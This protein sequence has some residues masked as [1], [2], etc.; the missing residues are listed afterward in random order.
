MNSEQSTAIDSD[1]GLQTKSAASSPRVSNDLLTTGTSDTAKNAA[2][3][4]VA[5]RFAVAIT[6]AM[7]DLI[8]PHD[9]A[10]PIARQFMPDAQELTDS[11]LDQADPIGDETHS[12][13]PGIVH[14]YPDRLLLTP[15]RVCPVYCRFCFRRETIGSNTS[16][17]LST[18]ELLTAI[19]YIRAHT[20]IWEVILSGGDPLLLSPRRLA[21]LIDQLNDIEHV[22]VIRIHTRVPVVSPERVSQQLV[23]ALRANKAVY[24]VLHSN[25]PRELTPAAQQACARL[26]DNGIPMLSQ[27]VLLK[28]INDDAATLEELFRLLVENR[29]KPYYLHHADRT[30]GTSHFRTSISEGQHLMRELRGKVSGLCQPEY[31]L[32]IPGGAGKVPVGPAWIEPAC[33]HSYTVTDTRGTAHDYNDDL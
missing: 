2:L 15:V 23:Q 6:P 7:L 3:A 22:K 24:V 25:H 28:G 1:A 27:S 18:A 30:A 5:T 4:Q 26:V 21:A 12:A 29:V 11:A 16:G 33:E 9:P 14:R 20:Q 10:D 8:D 32:D 31:V 19:E 13:L 17:T